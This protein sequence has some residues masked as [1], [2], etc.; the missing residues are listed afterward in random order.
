MSFVKNAQQK[1]L[2]LIAVTVV[3]SSSAVRAGD[4]VINEIMYHPLQPQFGSEPIAEE[5]IELF[6]KGT[7]PVNLNGWRF[8]K[9][10][11]FTFGSITLQPG[12][13]LVVSADIATFSDKHPGITNVV[14]NWIGNLGNNGET[15]EI[16]DAAGNVADSVSYGTEGD[17]AIRQRG[18]DD[19]GHRGWKWFSEADGMGKSMERRNSRIETDSGQNWSPS[20]SAGGTPGRVNSMV[21]ANIAPLIL[22]LAHSPLVPASTQTVA[23]TARIVDEQ[24][25]GN[26]A[27]LFWRVD[28]TTPPAFTSTP[29][30]D[31]GAH[32]DG[33]AAD[34]IYGAIIPAQANN[35]VIEFYVVATDAGARSSSWPG[36]VI[37]AV[38]GAGPT[39]QVANA[40]YEVD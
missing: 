1:A 5:F 17:W 36:P 29:M 9:S 16:K 13:Y 34:G 23:I 18:P 7:V 30:F 21:S 33:A 24:T 37:A 39:G 6:N 8:S 40:L 25:T 10:I 11:S 15:I 26:S 35:T 3:L 2:A 28:S 22:D 19:V 32:G 14:G 31:D 12:A 38:D 4:V 20:S 27:T